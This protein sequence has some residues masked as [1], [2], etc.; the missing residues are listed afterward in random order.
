MNKHSQ[1][2]NT[3]NFTRHETQEAAEIAY[4]Y[5]KINSKCEMLVHYNQYL[6]SYC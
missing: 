2:A 1:Q 5:P 4:F 6:D 3:K